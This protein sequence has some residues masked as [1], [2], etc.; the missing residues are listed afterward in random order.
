VVLA[1]LMRLLLSDG[2]WRRRA[3]SATAE[4]QH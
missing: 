3:A 2:P 1:V 4:I